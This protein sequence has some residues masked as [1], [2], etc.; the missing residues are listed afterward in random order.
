MKKQLFAFFLALPAS[1]AVSHAQETI[2]HF[3]SEVRVHSNGSISVE[4][5]I[6]VNSEG[7]RIRHGIYR[8][9][10]TVYREAGGALR[11]VGFRSLK[12][13]RNGLPEKRHRQRLE[14]GIRVYLG[15]PTSTIAPGDYTYTL[16]YQTDRQLGFFNDYDELF[17]NVTGN[18]WEFPIQRATSVVRVPSGIPPSSLSVMGYTGRAGSREKALTVRVAEDGACIFETT[19]SLGVGEGLSIVVRW[20][21]GVLH[22]P[23]LF[24]QLVF[25]SR[26]HRAVFDT[27]AV[28]LLVTFYFLWH[29]HREGRD[30]RPGIIA[31]LFEP[32][33]DLSPADLRFIEKMRFDDRTFAAALIDLAAR[34]AL[35]I[36]EEK[37]GFLSISGPVY[38]LRKNNT[39]AVV[40]PAEV[41]L[42]ERLFSHGDSFKLSKTHNICVESAAN[43]LEANLL[44]A[45]DGK[46][47]NRN[48]RAIAIGVL[49]TALGLTCVIYRLTLDFIEPGLWLALGALVL[50]N[51]FFGYIMKA[52]T[53]EGRALLDKIQGFRMF[54]TLAEKDRLNL[55]NPPE[56]TPA[57]FEKYLP[58]ALALGVEQRWG[59]QFAGI[60]AD[61]P[62]GVPYSPAWFRGSS[63]TGFHPQSFASSMAGRFTSLASAASD[64]PGTKSGWSSGGSP[65]GG[66]SGGGGGGG[67][68]GG[69]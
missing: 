47:F 56:R 42:L 7:L 22:P 31:P 12:T 48:T 3:H 59:E 26:D 62:K 15:D 1:A 29:W 41:T 46:A 58:Y 55:L 67:G 33:P 50:V 51:V 24:Q 57:L 11:V 8:D 40:P 35:T 16:R 10:P 28:I 52:P 18:G 65:G 63:A 66:S 21:K 61:Q 23:S 53:T 39:K 43:A 27:F 49:L 19:R 30:P 37:P 20:P 17:W 6:R 14:N 45:W 36:E 25:F 2:Q 54:L 13:L 34:S 64:P 60:F 69:W 32:P 9:F 44:A 68:G 38:T 4:E 5:T